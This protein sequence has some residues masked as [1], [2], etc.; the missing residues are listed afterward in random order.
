MHPFSHSLGKDQKEAI[1]ERHAHGRFLTGIIPGCRCGEGLR[2]Q[3]A[4]AQSLQCPLL[5]D[6]F[7]LSGRVDSPVPPVWQEQHANPRS[8]DL[9][10]LRSSHGQRR[11]VRRA[12]RNRFPKSV[13]PST[14]GW[15]DLAATNLG[16]S[17]S[18]VSMPW[19]LCPCAA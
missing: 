19:S 18:T 3:E 8:Q 10:T 15:L 11:V 17:C 14:A 9:W 12:Q 5:N 16:C 13:L 7:S 4:I 6:F 1:R 2:L